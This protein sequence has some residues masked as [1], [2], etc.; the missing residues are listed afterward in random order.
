M[1]SK[2]KKLLFLLW[3]SSINAFPSFPYRIGMKS[4]E[5]ECRIDIVDGDIYFN[6]PTFF[7]GG[8]ETLCFC[9]KVAEV[10]SIEKGIVKCACSKHVDRR[11]SVK[12]EEFSLE[13]LVEAKVKQI[14]EAYKKENK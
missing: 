3:V 9:G 11:E 2:M 10:V 14:E 13:D 8:R 5:L 7:I 12:Y 6:K 1:Q 4:V